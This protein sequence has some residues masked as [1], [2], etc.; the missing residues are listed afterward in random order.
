TFH[1]PF[2]R[3]FYQHPLANAGEC[4]VSG[5]ESKVSRW[6]GLPRSSRTPR[7]KPK[8]ASLYFWWASR[9]SCCVAMVEPPVFYLEFTV[10]PLSARLLSYLG[11]PAALVLLVVSYLFEHPLPLRQFLRTI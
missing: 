1:S 9:D 5:G 11:L 2:Q 10:L 4:K 7:S 6:V 8:M 3:R